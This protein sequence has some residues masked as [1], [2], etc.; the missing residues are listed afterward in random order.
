MLWQRDRQDRGY[1]HGNDTCGRELIPMKPLLP[2]GWWSRG[3]TVGHLRRDW[4]AVGVTS[5]GELRSWA[6]LAVCS[7]ARVTAWRQA[8]VGPVEARGFERRRIEPN[9]VLAWQQA[10]SCFEELDSWARLGVRDVATV[11]AW[12]AVTDGI[13]EVLAWQ[14][15]GVPPDRVEGLRAAGVDPEDRSLW[16][17]IGVI[18]PEDIAE[19]SAA[20]FTPARAAP[21]CADDVSPEQAAAWTAAGFDA[22]SSRGWRRAA[23]E[24]EHA[25][26]WRRH[27]VKLRTAVRWR[28]AGI[29]DA[30]GPL[31]FG[32]QVPR[33]T[34]AEKHAAGQQPPRPQRPTAWTGTA[35]RP[36]R[37][38]GTA[39]TSSTPL[40]ADL[41]ALELRAEPPAAEDPEPVVTDG[42]AARGTPEPASQDQ[43]ALEPDPQPR[44]EP[45]AERAPELEP[46]PEP[47]PES[48]PDH[49]PA[50]WSDAG[51]D[52]V[53]WGR[54]RSVVP[55]PQHVVAL[56][57][58]G[59]DVEAVLTW[60][61]HG[62]DD[63]TRMVAL[64]QRG[65]APESAKAWSDLG[66]S[67]PEE[68]VEWQRRWDPGSAARWL[69]AAGG[70]IEEAWR[71]TNTVDCPDEVARWIELGFVTSAWVEDVIRA[72][73]RPAP[74]SLH[75][76]EQLV[77]AGV[78]APEPAHPWLQ[79]TPVKD[80]ERWVAIGALAPE[81]AA[82]WSDAGIGL[83]SAELW[84]SMDV[85]VAEAV[86]WLEL[87]LEPEAARIW[88]E[89]LASP[90]EARTWLSAGV[91]PDE[92]IGWLTS[93]VQGPD[94]ACELAAI[95]FSHTSYAAAIAGKDE[96]EIH[97]VIRAQAIH[98]AGLALEDDLLTIAFEDP[99]DDPEG[100]LL[101]VA[102]VAAAAA[103]SGEVH[104]QV[105]HG[106]PHLSAAAIHAVPDARYVRGRLKAR[107]FDA[108]CSG[109]LA[110]LGA[111]LGVHQLS[112]DGLPQMDG[113]ATVL[114]LEPSD[115]AEEYLR[116]PAGEVG[117]P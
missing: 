51:L 49:V 102:R 35:V 108:L 59:L 90:Q 77:R 24:P 114:H 21:W 65:I 30:D 85:P 112:E 32:A 40:L 41:E 86:E 28:A 84:T 64:R 10:V 1:G 87:G 73:G 89:G 62:F 92:A 11:V 38:A 93:G 53:S 104:L 46:E 44:P 57:D 9:E 82:A 111:P 27:G 5:F 36:E 48:E 81:Q 113:P 78:Q 98:A 94:R 55:H 45:D 37:P 14:R 39:A 116:I 68:M 29:P 18:A 22:R 75:T 31:W 115:P 7:P 76:V 103:A 105:V 60:R 69:D 3:V 71:W 17:R 100:A 106:A 96:R 15:M 74:E 56:R 109:E 6:A 97:R 20:G 42:A 91:D 8:G 33:R 66:L 63:P 52:E 72:V 2:I 54:W 95:G 12:K 23:W 83:T 107:L 88:C 99:G 19:W 79:D 58:A 43:A 110:A 50:E 67:Q 47:E 61:N 117:R 25:E 4:E 101:T 34:A 16:R 26:A 80:V 70:T 13:A